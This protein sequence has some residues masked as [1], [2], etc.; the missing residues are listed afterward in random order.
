MCGIVAAVGRK[1][2]L[3]LLIDGL[4]KLEY[5]GYDSTGVGFLQADNHIHCERSLERV[6]QLEAQILAQNFI[7]HVGMA[8]TRG[9]THGAPA[10]RNAHPMESHG[11]GFDISLVHNGIIENHEPLREAL[12]ARG[13]TFVSETD[14]EVIAHLVHWELEQGGTLRDAHQALSI[15]GRTGPLRHWRL[16]VGQDSRFHPLYPAHTSAVPCCGG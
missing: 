5:R 14:T 6:A 4:K 1:N 11:G 10:L 13:Y 2:I 15:H 8:H 12:K 9:A 16:S 7:A 3:P